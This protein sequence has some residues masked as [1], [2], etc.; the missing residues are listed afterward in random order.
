MAHHLEGAHAHAAAGD[1]ELGIVGGDEVAE[2]GQ[3]LF[4]IVGHGAD[5]DHLGS[6]GGEGRGQARPV[7]VEGGAVGQ[8]GGG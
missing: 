4:G 6:G 5:V 3:E 8:V 1:D 7:G 2:G